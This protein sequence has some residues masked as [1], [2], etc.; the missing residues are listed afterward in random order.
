M[1]TSVKLGSKGFNNSSRVSVIVHSL[2]HNSTH[3]LSHLTTSKETFSWWRVQ[4]LNP[5][6][7]LYLL[8]LILILWVVVTKCLKTL[9]VTINPLL[10]TLGISFALGTLNLI[11][12]WIAELTLFSASLY[13]NAWLYNYESS[14][15]GKNGVINH[16]LLALVSG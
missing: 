14:E 5:G 7:L 12:G 4:S 11:K 2:K 9:T 10:S 13:N 1:I 3:Q 16:T 8:L 6:K 15:K